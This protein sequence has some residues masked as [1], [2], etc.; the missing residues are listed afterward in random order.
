[1]RTS[2]PRGAMIKIRTPSSANYSAHRCGNNGPHDISI[3]ARYAKISSNKS[4][5]YR[6]QLWTAILGLAVKKL[7]QKFKMIMFLSVFKGIHKVMIHETTIRGTIWWFCSTLIRRLKINYI[8]MID[9]VWCKS[10]FHKFEFEFFHFFVIPHQII[11][12]RSGVLDP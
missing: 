6:S 12:H 11:T 7:L 10:S 2:H 8:D 9:C 3:R 5:L 4:G 1:M